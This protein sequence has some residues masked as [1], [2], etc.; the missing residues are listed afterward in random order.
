[1]VKYRRRSDGMKV[2][3]EIFEEDGQL[4]A[5]LHNDRAEF[6][7]RE[8]EVCGSCEEESKPGLSFP[9]SPW[10]LELDSFVERY[11]PVAPH[12]KVR[13][14]QEHKERSEKKNAG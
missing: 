1:M 10:C 7:V 6:V 4:L 12:P 2:D 3:V 5:R 11:K 9:A 8:P 13:L 14:L